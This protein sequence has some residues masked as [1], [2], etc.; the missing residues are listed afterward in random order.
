MRCGR[1]T[2]LVVFLLL[3]AF[4]ALAQDAIVE[5]ARALIQAGNAQEAYALLAP[6]EEQRAGEVEYDYLLGLAALD[7]GQYTRAVF[8]LERVLAMRPQHAQARAEIARAYFVM[9]ENQAARQEF[10]AAKRSGP[11]QAAAAT[12]DQFLSALDARERLGGRGFNAFLEAGIG[13]DSNVNSA[14]ATASFAIPLFPG[15]QFNLAPAAR[16]QDDEF[17]TVA[18]GAF[19]RYVLDNAWA[20]VSSASFDQ[21]FNAEHDEFDTG[22]INA[23]VGLSRIHERDEL[24]V[25][26]QGQRYSVERE[27]LRHAVG[28]VAQWRRNFTRRDQG[29]V[30]L[31]YARL[32]Y[33]DQPAHDADRTVLGG[34]WARAYNGLDAAF[35]GAYAGRE[36]ARRNGAGHFGHDLWGVRVGGQLGLG[37]RTILATTVSYEDR[38]YGGEDPFFLK[39]R[40]DREW[41]LRLAAHYL[42]DRTW[43]A[44]AVLTVIEAESNIVV[45][46][47]E[48]ALFTLSLRYEFR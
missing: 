28:G 13:L 21:R 16:R 44:I 29:T 38:R 37:S 43:S 34:A 23:A 17:A 10:E 48:R 9:G 20:L 4:R 32:D 26:A 40:H 35:A 8:A 45:N 6:L 2:G 7:T 41:Q 1:R 25:A 30:Y 14:T 11:P 5:R 18:G 46:D 15:L 31:Q 24:T 47:Y 19:G 22:T 33:P 3:L 12:I 39:E 27:A 36:E 42:I